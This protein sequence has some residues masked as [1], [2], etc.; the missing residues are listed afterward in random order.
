MVS[1]APSSYLGYLGT[2]GGTLELRSRRTG[3][4]HL[5]RRRGVAADRAQRR[6]KK[7]YTWLERTDAHVGRLREGYA[8]AA[9]LRCKP[10]IHVAR[11]WA[12][13]S[14]WSGRPLRDW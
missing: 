8:L 5:R 3:A 1:P 6:L 2:T 7:G 14:R 13:E 10:A 12:V 11:D 9:C 4:A